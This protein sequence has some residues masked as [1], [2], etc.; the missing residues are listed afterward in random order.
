MANNDTWENTTAM[1]NSTGN[2]TA[3]P[4]LEPD[5]IFNEG[6]VIAIVTYSILMVI[7]AIGNSTVLVLIRR[8]KGNTRSRINTMLMHLAIAD[9][10]VTFIM[11]PTE[12]GWAATVS[13]NAGDA[14]C[15][16]MAF[17]RMF[18]LYLSSFV[19]VCISVDR[20]YAV[21][22]P[23]H[24][25]DVDR[26]GKVMLTIAWVGSTICSLPQ[27]V[28]FH[29]DNHPVFTWYEQCITYNTFPSYTHELTY[30]LFGM[31]VMYALPLIVIIFSYAS[32]IIEIYKRSRESFTDKMRRSSLGFLGRAKIRTLKMTIIIVLVFFVCWTPY[33]VM[34]LWYWIDRPSAQKVDL[35]I[36]KCLFLFACTNSC[37]NPIVYGVF[38]IRSRKRDRKPVRA[39][40]IETRVT[41]LFLSV[42]LLS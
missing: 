33:Y 18:G 6:H 25:M 34:S 19:L 2:T 11:M 30:S 41:P 42:K 13:W 29:V 7:S 32:I 26:R 23:L 37:M 36:Q 15:R 28:V 12:I 4:T 8:R 17:F 16:I 5:M 21:L 40:T 38:N 27:M 14:M 10:L 3:E 1:L 39:P 35:R 9:L 24:L 20:Y 31:V 22:K